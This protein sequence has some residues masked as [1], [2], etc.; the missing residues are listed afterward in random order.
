MIQLAPAAILAAESSDKQRQ[1]LLDSVHRMSQLYDL[2]KSLNATLEMEAVTALIP[3][4]AAAML[5]C[6]AIHLWMFDGEILRLVS[7]H[8]TDETVSVGM[9]HAPGEGYVAD[10]AEE[11]ESLLIDD[12]GDERLA[13]RNAHLTSDASPVTNAL[14]V[15]LM[16]DDA[17]VGVLEA[18]NKDDGIFDDDDQFLMMSMAETIASALKNASLML[19]ERKLEILKTLV[20]V[21]G[22]ITSTLRLDRLMGIIVNSYN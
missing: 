2:E 22:E 17:E 13:V 4:K 11:G 10:M 16:Q 8:G 14:L 15:P 18:V 9:M 20:Q 7:T 12:A 1:D 21:S 19:A 3:V 6:Q 5:P